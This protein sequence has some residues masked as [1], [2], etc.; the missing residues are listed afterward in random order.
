MR[1]CNGGKK[2]PPRQ[3]VLVGSPS[4]NHHVPSWHA[5]R[6]CQLSLLSWLW[7]PR[8]FPMLSCASL[9]QCPSNQILLY[10]LQRVRDLTMQ[11]CISD[12]REGIGWSQRKS[13]AAS[14]RWPWPMPRMRVTMSF[15]VTQICAS[16]FWRASRQAVQN[17]GCVHSI[18]SAQQ[19]SPGRG[20][21]KENK[22][23]V[24][25]SQRNHLARGGQ[26]LQSGSDFPICFWRGIGCRRAGCLNLAFVCVRQAPLR[27]SVSRRFDTA[28]HSAVK[29]SGKILAWGKEFLTGNDF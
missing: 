4:T 6:T 16:N 19:A 27:R 10:A 9:R 25:V 24:V 3:S 11:I 28:K 21:A 2:T 8:P 12:R 14:S 7:A 23:E 29:N 5:R 15:Q 17:V 13:V 26:T 20:Q 1:S 18:V 22:P